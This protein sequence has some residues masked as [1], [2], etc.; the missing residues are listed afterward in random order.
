MLVVSYKLQST[1][2]KNYAKLLLLFFLLLLLNIG[3]HEKKEKKNRFNECYN[4]TFDQINV[5]I[6][7]FDQLML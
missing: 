2:Q 1:I 4:I 7:F 5:I 3:G 6:Q